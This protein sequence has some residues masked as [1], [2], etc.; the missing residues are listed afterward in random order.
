[1]TL[2]SKAIAASALVILVCIGV[3]SFRSEVR[4]ERDREWVTHTLLV[5]EKLQAVRIDI[6]QA[7]TGQRGYMLT[8]QDRYLGLYQAGVMRVRRDMAELPDLT[9]DNPAEQ[10]AIQRLKP[11]IESRLTELADG[12]E[13][14]R[15]SGL[16]AGVE[17]VAHG[18]GGDMWME[19]IAAQI[20]E[21]RR[22][23]AR[24]LAG[25]LQTA[26][27]STRKIK[28]AIV[29][30]NTLAILILL[31]KGVVIQR[32]TGKRNLAER[33]LQQS[34]ERL[35][36]RTSELSDTN[37][38]LESFTY[39]VAHDLRAPLRHIAGYAGV[40]V[41]DYG[42]NLD[43]KG[44]GH[45]E[46]IRLGAEKMGRLVDDLLSLSG[47]GRQ[48][49]T[50]QNTSLDALLQQ[51]LGELAPEFFGRELEWRIGALSNA[52]CDPGLMKQVFVN[53]LSNA[54]K[55]TGKRE[56]AIIEVGEMMRD[57]ERVLFVRDNGVGFEMQYAGK[58]FGVFQRLHKA[59]DFQGTGVGLAIVHRI[60][61]RH[62]GRIWAE[63]EPD[64][65]A[66]FFFTLGLPENEASQPTEVPQDE[67]MHV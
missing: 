50:L 63:A 60:V 8:G 14:R 58:L 24:L 51:V 52:E 40:L 41:E 53:L 11:L 27:A 17:A 56:R 39:S 4:N 64:R 23:E 25:R 9:A 10:G 2:S 38:E 45:L 15:Q 59:T 35:E 33:G 22:T 48:E 46:K 3:L 37:I 42:A 20:A 6:T 61:R 12:I 1:V 49:L 66:T 18:N 47:I 5:V 62:G 28:A 55:Y 21:M 54:V 34:N 29:V 31:I 32:E 44:G 7:E 36:R 30:G 43:T 57:D 67:V 26:A 19:L 65:G 16:L 13:V